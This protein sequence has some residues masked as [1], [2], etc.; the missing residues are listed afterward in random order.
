VHEIRRVEPDAELDARYNA[1]HAKIIAGRDGHLQR[2]IDD[3]S[4][5]H[6]RGSA[7]RAAVKALADGACVAAPVVHRDFYGDVVPSYWMVTDEPGSPGSVACAEAFQAGQSP[8]RG[9]PVEAL[10]RDR[11]QVL[12]AANR[13]GGPTMTHYYLDGDQAIISFEVPPSQDIN[14]DAKCWTPVNEEWVDCPGSTG[15]GPDVLYSGDFYPIPAESVLDF[16]QR[17]RD[18]MSRRSQG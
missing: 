5:W 15:I 4:V 3:G 8:A 18:A 1:I 17:C 7:G 10:V 12:P 13:V 9:R 6:A 2:G 14:A 16:Q 11:R